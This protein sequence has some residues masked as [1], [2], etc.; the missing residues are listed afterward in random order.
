MTAL[1]MPEVAVW[2]VLLATEQPKPTGSRVLPVTDV[3]S[4]DVQGAVP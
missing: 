2:R 1:T 3:P 4:I